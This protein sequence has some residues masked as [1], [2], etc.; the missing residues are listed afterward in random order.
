MAMGKG[1]MD[2]CAIAQVVEAFAQVEIRA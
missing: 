2:H 1:D